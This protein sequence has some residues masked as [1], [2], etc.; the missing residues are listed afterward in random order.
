MKA[1]QTI[2]AMMPLTMMAMVQLIVMIPV[3]P[4]V[5]NQTILGARL[6][7]IRFRIN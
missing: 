5:V 7:P 2:I 4:L 1:V 3:V 6:P